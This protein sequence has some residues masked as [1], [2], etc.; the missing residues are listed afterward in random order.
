MLQAHY[1]ENQTLGIITLV[2]A[3]LILF[4]LT[5]TVSLSAG[6]DD[7][8]LDSFM[9]IKITSKSSTDDLYCTQVDKDTCNNTDFVTSFCRS[10]EWCLGY[11]K[12][13]DEYHY[14]VDKTKFESNYDSAIDYDCNPDDENTECTLIDNNVVEKYVFDK[15]TFFNKLNFY[16]KYKNDVIELEKQAS[17]NVGISFRKNKDQD[18][19]LV[20][21]ITQQKNGSYNVLRGEYD[22]NG[23]LSSPFVDIPEPLDYLTYV[24]ECVTN[25]GKLHYKSLRE[26]IEKN[27]TRLMEMYPVRFSYEDESTPACNYDFT[28]S[29]RP[30]GLDKYYDKF[31]IINVGN[32]DYPGAIYV[33]GTKNST[34]E[35]FD[36]FVRVV[37]KFI[38]SVR[39]PQKG[40]KLNNQEIY[41]INYND[42]PYL[43]PHLKSR[44]DAGDDKLFYMTYGTRSL[45]YV[46]QYLTIISE[47]TICKRGIQTAYVIGN[48][49]DY[50]GRLWGHA[51]HHISTLLTSRLELSKPIEKILQDNYINGTRTF[52]NQNDSSFNYVQSPFFTT[53]IGI[54]TLFNQNLLYQD[55]A[56]NREDMQ[57]NHPEIYNY[58]T[59]VFDVN[60]DQVALCSNKEDILAFNQLSDDDKFKVLYELYG[61]SYSQPD[62]TAYKRLDKDCEA[63]NSQTW[64]S[65]YEHNAKGTLQAYDLCKNECDNNEKCTGFSLDNNDNN[66]TLRSLDGGICIPPK[67]SPRGWSSEISGPVYYVK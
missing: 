25:V 30:K 39:D 37:S 62:T 8:S 54:Y 17:A 53:V 44:F 45:S 51:L 67:N 61:P 29:S 24:D 63:A 15:T 55:F 7:Y 59:S 41:L 21:F 6:I 66:C 48:K 5:Y 13:S 58:L 38:D 3:M 33:I 57:I 20:D 43:M 18:G 16:L 11:A 47:E 31:K 10:S 56:K 32:T 50:T 65:I 2:R 14:I 40:I 12:I 35:M 27:K 42:A 64:S 49:Q 19:V 23:N 26:S 36:Q 28:T 4:S 34:Q 1:N 9:R 22:S 60:S 46:D 52:P